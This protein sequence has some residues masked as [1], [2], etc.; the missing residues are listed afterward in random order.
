MSKKGDNNALHVLKTQLGFFL[1]NEKGIIFESPMTEPRDGTFNSIEDFLP[2]AAIAGFH[3]LV[4]VCWL[5][6]KPNLKIIPSICKKLSPDSFEPGLLV[7][8]KWIRKWSIPPPARLRMLSA[9]RPVLRQVL[10]R[11]YQM[12]Y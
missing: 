7:I 5:N 2:F 12:Q 6:Y 10:F 4:W 9:V 3:N 8:V 11:S 1:H